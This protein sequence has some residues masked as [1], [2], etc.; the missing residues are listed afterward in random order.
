M[1]KESIENVTTLLE[2]ITELLPGKI[3]EEI[4]EVA[5]VSADWVSQVR[6][7]KKQSAPVQM[8]IATKAIEKGRKLVE[9]GQKLTAALA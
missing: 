7:G 8:A 1:R 2:E 9:L 6:N 3:N 5:E 4:A